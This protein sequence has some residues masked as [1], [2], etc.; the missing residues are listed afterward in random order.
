M[1][2]RAQIASG[3][4]AAAAPCFLVATPPALHYVLWRETRA[5]RAVQLN[6]RATDDLPHYVNGLRPEQILY[7]APTE[8]YPAER[9]NDLVA[10]HRLVLQA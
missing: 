1:S 5:L 6:D 7:V 3:G 10:P 2:R 9:I 4:Y 8:K